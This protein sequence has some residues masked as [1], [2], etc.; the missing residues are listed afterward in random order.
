[1]KVS[2]KAARVN[3]GMT[4]TEAAKAIKVNPSTLGNWEKGKSSP[5]ADKAKQLCDL[6]GATI[7]DIFFETR[8]GL[9]G[10][11]EAHT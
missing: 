11:P 2:L 5:P 3:A 7:D 4:Q 8:S 9:T 1:M 6:Y 10:V